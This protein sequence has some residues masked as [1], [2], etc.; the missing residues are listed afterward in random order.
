MK[1]RTVQFRAS[2]DEV[3]AFKKKYGEEKNMNSVAKELFLSNVYG[4]EEKT[5]TK[6]LIRI[7]TILQQFIM[8]MNGEVD[9]GSIFTKAEEDEKE[10]LRKLGF[11]ND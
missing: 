6:I 7:L 2:N 3:A 4:I 11:I 9:V 10:Y 1:Q 8:E 5:D